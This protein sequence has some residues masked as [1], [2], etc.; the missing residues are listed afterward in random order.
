MRKLFF[1]AATVLIGLG[2]GLPA[3]AQP[4]APTGVSLFFDDFDGPAL[5]RSH[6]TVEVGP[7][8]AANNEQQSYIGDTLRIVHG[9]DADGVASALEI[10]P[11]FRDASRNRAPRRGDFLSARLNTKGKAEFTYGTL[12]AR[13]KLS[14]GKG[15]WPAFWAMGAKGAWPANGEIDIMEN[16]GDPAWT[17]FAMHGSGY[18]GNTPITG[19]AEFPAENDT[20]QWHVYS[21]DLTKDAAVFRIDGVEKYRVSRADISK[22]GPWAYDN[23]KYLLLNLALG[24]VY[25]ASMSGMQNA[26]YPGITAET[27][28]LI[29][30]GK[31]RMLVDWVKVT[32]EP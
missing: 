20:T 16:G 23:S 22:H 31:V 17:T 19:R 26:P 10:K 12:A 11:Q 5:D 8:T 32:A 1:V 24:G 13:I 21:V 27:V 7:G 4:G 3:K 15:L 18:S 29:K 9:P 6:W 2:A 14:A 28:D 25:T 30:A